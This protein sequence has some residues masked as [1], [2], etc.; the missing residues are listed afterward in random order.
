M[1]KFPNKFKKTLFLA[2][3]PHFWGNNIFFKKIRLCHT[4][5][6]MGFQHHADFQK[7]QENLQREEQK[8]VQTHP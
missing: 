5:H 2:Q 1:T 7:F 6:R 4:Q 8:E 3:F